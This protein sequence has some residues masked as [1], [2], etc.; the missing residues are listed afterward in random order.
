MI[1]RKKLIRWSSYTAYFIAVFFLFLVFLLPYDRIKGRL[2]S[3]VRT[4]TP[5]ELAIARLRP[6]FLNRFRLEEVVVSDRAGQVLF[7]SPSVNARVSLFAL[8]RG[9]TAVDLSGK[10]YGGDL[11]VRAEQGAKRRFLSVDATDLDLGSYMLF[12]NLGLKLSGRLGGSYEMTDDSG[13]GKFWI[14]DFTSRELKVQGF[15]VPDLDFEQC[16]IEADV[17][18][19]RCTI[20]KLDLE[21]KDLKVRVTGD[22]VMRPQ[23]TLNLAI[24]L[25][26]SERLAHEQ[27]GLL[28]LLKNKDPEGYYL[29]S[30]GGT[31]ASP[32]PR[33]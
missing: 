3:E 5:V 9:I 8:L 11:T 23:G 1:D 13:K 4:R 25:K 2:E 26:P 10:A 24:R 32:L 18:G 27:A 7:E 15:P 16:W 22:L 12:R 21:G 17:K 28:S 20:R 33:L 30:L 29:F 6:R 31:L 19:D 14:K